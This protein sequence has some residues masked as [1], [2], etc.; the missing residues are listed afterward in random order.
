[1]VDNQELAK[2]VVQQAMRFGAVELLR[3]KAVDLG[4][5]R[6]AELSSADGHML[7][8]VH[9]KLDLEVFREKLWQLGN[10]I[11]DMQKRELGEFGDL[12]L[13]LL[14]RDAKKFAFLLEERP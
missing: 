7:A 5:L 13:V 12:V 9:E 1:M 3:D 11:G 4:L 10:Q 2:Q 6:E 14:K 8:E